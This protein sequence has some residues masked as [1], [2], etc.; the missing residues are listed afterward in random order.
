V[1]DL[2]LHQQ[3]LAAPANA[4]GR[5]GSLPTRAVP[6]RAARPT[7]ADKAARRLAR[8]VDCI[9][10]YPGDELLAVVADALAQV[11]ADEAT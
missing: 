4:G 9:L 8:A 3:A 1:T 10:F 5:S 7:A 6:A 2:P 11:D